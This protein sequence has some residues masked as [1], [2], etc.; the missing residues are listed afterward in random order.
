MTGSKHLLQLGRRQ[1]L[2]DCGLFQGLK[3]LRLRNWQAPPVD[4]AGLE[5]IL[6]S[7]AHLD[8]TGALPLWVRHGFRGPIVCTPGTA[9]LLPLLLRDSAHLQ[10]EDA[11]LANKGGYSTHHPALPLYTLQDAEAALKLVERRPYDQPFALAPGVTVTFRR[12]GHILG[13]S[14]IEVQLEGPPPLRLVYSGDLGRPHQ[15]ILRDPE[16]I[17]E[18]DV[19]LVES[20]YGNRTHA[21]DPTSALARI[22]QE[23]VQRGG[24]LL[25][26]AFAVGRAQELLWMVRELEQAG[27][28]PS[29]PVYL[30][31]PMAIDVTALYCQ[32]TEDHDVD[33]AALVRRHACPLEATWYHLTRT[34]EESQALERLTGPCLILSASGMATGGRILHHLQARL[35]DLHTT[36]LL[37]GYQAAG[38]RGRALQEGATTVKIHGQQIPVRAKIEVL[39]GLSAHADQ[40]EI[41]QWLSGFRRAPRHLY[42]VHGEPEASTVLAQVI[43]STLHWPVSVAVDG[44]RVPLT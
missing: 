19:L 4:P 22:I 41:L 23:A 33:M 32:H 12:A 36:V 16:P 13:A 42:L 37:A 44:A 26:P 1:F 18:A 17:R 6:V 34:P 9:D 11:A 20:T 43:Q 38:T 24:A 35:P 39:D 8:H 21:P 14:T 28:I 40:G 31:S 25:I 29:L 5:A 30:D 3:A 2:L 15:P 10:E 7:H 27:R